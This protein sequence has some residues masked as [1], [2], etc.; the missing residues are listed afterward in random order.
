M[1]G[2]RREP[3]GV[4]VHKDGSSEL[5]QPSS[6]TKL[7]NGKLRL[8]APIAKLISSKCERFFQTVLFVSIPA[9]SMDRISAF[10]NYVSSDLHYLLSAANSN[11]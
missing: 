6:S 5:L 7:E 11:Q 1:D 3:H 4:V 10:P 9:S 8:T 2:M